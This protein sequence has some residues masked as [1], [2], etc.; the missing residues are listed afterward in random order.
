MSEYAKIDVNFYFFLYLFA[1]TGVIL[2]I[3]KAL[4]QSGVAKEDVNYINAHATSTPAGDIKEFQALLHCFGQNQEVCNCMSM[5]LSWDI[6]NKLS[7]FLKLIY[8]IQRYC[9]NLFKKFTI[10]SPTTN[11]FNNE[12]NQ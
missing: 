6:Q 2:C 8:F 5:F 12:D 3:E 7:M 1:G 10:M 11:Y 9:N 4:A